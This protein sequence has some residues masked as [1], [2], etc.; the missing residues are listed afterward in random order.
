MPKSKEMKA[1]AKKGEKKG[2]KKGVTRTHIG[3]SPGIIRE[4]SPGWPPVVTIPPAWMPSLRLLHLLRGCYTQ[5]ELAEM[6]M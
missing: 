4:E 5:K 3:P 6:G 2:E 1:A